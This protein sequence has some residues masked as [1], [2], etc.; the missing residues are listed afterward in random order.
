MTSPLSNTV[1]RELRDCSLCHVTGNA[2]WAH[3]GVCACACKT[4]C[5][6]ACA[7]MGP[8]AGAGAWCSSAS[9][10]PGASACSIISS[11]GAWAAWAL[12]VWVRALRNEQM[13]LICYHRVIVMHSS[14][15][16]IKAKP[17]FANRQCE[18]THTHTH[19]RTYAHARTHTCCEVSAPSLPGLLGGAC[20]V[21]AWGTAVGA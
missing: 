16:H 7:C 12:P 1:C 6:C 5:A 3:E 18:Q 21:R 20:C 17:A 13:R 11:A 15:K 2:N 8:S 19:T 4:P 14:R 10:A 9:S